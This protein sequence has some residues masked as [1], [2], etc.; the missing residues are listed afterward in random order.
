MTNE[1]IHVIYGWNMI[2]NDWYTDDTRVPTSDLRLTY[3]KS[4]WHTDDMRVTYEWYMNTYEGYLLYK[5]SGA[6]RS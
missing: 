6:F 4:E 5:A 1:Y 2:I 3:D